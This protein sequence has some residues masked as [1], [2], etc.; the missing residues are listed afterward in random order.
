MA[1]WL[2]RLT[3]NQMG[4][5]RVGSNPARSA[6]FE[7]TR[8]HHSTTFLLFASL[9]KRDSFRSCDGRVVK[10]FWSGEVG[11]FLVSVSPQRTQWLKCKSLYFNYD[12]KEMFVVTCWRYGEWLTSVCC[13]LNNVWSYWPVCEYIVRLSRNVLGL[14][15]CSAAVIYGGGPPTTGKVG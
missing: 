4:S 6:K 10:A 2:R 14:A 8:K 12:R 5:S 1:E 3:R 9:Q 13:F 7:I 15:C 11:Y